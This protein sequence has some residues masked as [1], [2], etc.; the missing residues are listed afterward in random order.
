M[1]SSLLD[2]LSVLVVTILIMGGSSLKEPT[3]YGLE[4]DLELHHD[5]GELFLL[6]EDEIVVKFVVSREYDWY[7]RNVSNCLISNFKKHSLY[8][9]IPLQ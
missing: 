7:D 4:E 5:K 3:F 6:K 1:K 9:V 2:Q 8:C